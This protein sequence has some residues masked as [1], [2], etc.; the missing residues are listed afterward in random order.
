MKSNSGTA[1]HLPESL[2][3]STV[4]PK[5]LAVGTIVPPLAESARAGHPVR[6]FCRR[7]QK[8]GPLA[9]FN[10]TTR[11]IAI[12]G[13]LALMRVL[14]GERHLNY[15]LAS[16]ISITVSSIVIFLVSDGW[17]FENEGFNDK[18]NQDLST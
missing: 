7:N 15:L 17:V 4:K 11:A 18:C 14:V 12:V 5:A 2:R 1:A 8:G 13:N 9:R 3:I 16:A 10:P 6:C